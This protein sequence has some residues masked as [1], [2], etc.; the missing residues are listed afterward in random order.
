MNMPKTKKKII[1]KA[2][3]EVIKLPSDNVEMIPKFYMDCIDKYKFKK[4]PTE[5]IPKEIN[6]LVY[7]L[8]Y[9]DG[10]IMIGKIKKINEKKK[11]Y[12]IEELETKYPHLSTYDFDGVMLVPPNSKDYKKFDRR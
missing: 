11:W 12:D 3:P 2:K 1:R 10:T 7:Y 5:L 4:I 6:S 8:D 9:K